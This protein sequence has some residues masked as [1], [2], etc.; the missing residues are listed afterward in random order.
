MST[1]IVT[2]LGAVTSV[3]MDAV[4]TCASIRAGLSR[5]ATLDD[6]E[7][8]DL[9]EHAPIG[10][11]AHPVAG[12][13][14]GFSGVG[15]WLQLAG[16]ALEDL[17]RS[18]QLPGAAHHAFWSATRL[19][20]VV[21]VLDGQRFPLDPLC[22]SEAELV[23]SLAAP[24]LTR[25]ADCFADN[26]PG[27]LA[28][29]FSLSRTTVRAHGRTGALAAV[30]DAEVEFSRGESE[31]AVILAV[32]SL[33]DPPSLE[34]LGELGRL[35]EDENPV[36][37]MP[38]EGAVG[39]MIEAPRAARLRGAPALARIAAVATDSEPRAFLAGERSLGEALARTVEAALAAA[40]VPLPYV[41]ETLADLNGEPWRAEEYGHARVRVRPDRWA[42]EA[43]EMP[44]AS[45]GDIG[46]GMTALQVVLA[47]RSLARGYAGGDQVLLTASDEYGGVGAAVI[48][49]AG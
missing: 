29:R 25:M 2:A 41:A 11:T 4:T 14:L 19:H 22:A 31:R 36:G 26:L 33:I 46:A 13:T 24:L 47:C 18:G 7:V 12:V 28:G 39:F 15:R 1:A 17:C 8:L 49:K 30:R 9:E 32:D 48:G 16:L 27:G 35:K 43:V 40:A 6:F 5:P 37:L 42:S 20:L 45:V 38:G 3:G 44:A 23:A 34:W 21:P 10:L